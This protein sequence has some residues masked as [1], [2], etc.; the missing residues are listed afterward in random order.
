MPCLYGAFGS[1]DNAVIPNIALFPINPMLD[2]SEIT[3]KAIMQPVKLAPVC[4]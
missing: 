2:F 1:I 3:H 4:G